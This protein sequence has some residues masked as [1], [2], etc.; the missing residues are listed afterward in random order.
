MV[1][2]RAASVVA[3]V[4]AG[5]AALGGQ[6]RNSPHD[7]SGRSAGTNQRSG[8]AV[9][10]GLCTF[11]HTP[12]K[13]QSTRLLWNHSYSGVPQYFWSDVT[14]TS[15]GTPLP[16]I[17]QDWTGPSKFCLSCHDGTVAI[18][19]IVWF[20]RRSWTGAS[21]LDDANARDIVKGGSDGDLKNI[22]PLAAPYP[23]L[24]A[25]STYNGVTTGTGVNLSRYRPDPR[26]LG[27][28]LFNDTGDAV[29]AVPIA[30]R[31]GIECTSCHAVHN[32]RGIVKD[33]PL[34]RANKDAL[35]STTCHLIDM[36]GGM[37]PL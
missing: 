12:H 31:T 10:T 20:N 33:S 25:R 26:P 35:C 32:E 19:D 5:T 23:F 15:G 34:L 2:A 24:Q 30:G 9:T 16:V 14:Q 22:H 36:G 7:F 21:N 37:W 17:R 28:R 29:V 11:C 13:A 18:G 3:F 8:S 27:V 6:L 1:F 4:A